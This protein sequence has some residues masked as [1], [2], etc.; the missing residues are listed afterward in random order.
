MSNVSANLPVKKMYGKKVFIC[1]CIFTAA[2][3]AF[4]MWDE[5]QQRERRQVSVKYRMLNIQ[6][7]NNMNE[8]ELQKQKYQE[9]KANNS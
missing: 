9:Y 8:Y 4:V 5:K 3:I 6:Q 7:Q 1:T 2:T